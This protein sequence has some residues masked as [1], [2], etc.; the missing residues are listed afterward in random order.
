MLARVVRGQ[1]IESER[2]EEPASVAAEV[3]PEPLP[4]E[5][6]EEPALV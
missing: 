1:M 5:R 2:K 4:W 3:P 6:E